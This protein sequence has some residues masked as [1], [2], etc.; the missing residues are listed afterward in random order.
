M[1]VAFGQPKARRQEAVPLAEQQSQGGA[2]IALSAKRRFCARPHGRIGS[3]RP[4][5]PE[6]S[7]LR[8]LLRSMA[9][10]SRL[11]EV[12]AIVNEHGRAAVSR[13]AAVR[14][15]LM[16]EIT[17][18]HAPL[19]L[20]DFDLPP[21]RLAQHPCSRQGSRGSDMSRTGVSAPGV[22]SPGRPWLSATVHAQ[23]AENGP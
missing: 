5:V 19:S 23:R 18:A 8:W 17:V 22:G 16:P 1:E 11:D 20:A 6:A 13:A 4:S 7:S 10:A 3:D 21:G 2:W 12:V 15:D 9:D 14:M